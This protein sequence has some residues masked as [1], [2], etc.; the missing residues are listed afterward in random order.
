MDGSKPS[1]AGGVQHTLGAALR[2][3]YR[4]S[5]AGKNPTVI[6]RLPSDDIILHARQIVRMWQRTGISTGG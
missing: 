3:A 4:E 1:A 6:V 2:L 5:M